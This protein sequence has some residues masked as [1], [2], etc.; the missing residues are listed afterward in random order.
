[1]TRLHYLQR[2]QQKKTGY[3]RQTKNIKHLSAFSLYFSFSGAQ[4]GL[5]LP[6]VLVCYASGFFSGLFGPVF[7]LVFLPPELQAVARGRA[8]G[9]HPMLTT[10]RSL[11]KRAAQPL[12]F[13]II[14]SALSRASLCSVVHDP[15][16][17]W[18]FFTLLQIGLSQL[19]A[20]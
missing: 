10:N 13:Q 6:A 4:L 11:H 14:P 7:V 9:K 19:P 1:M 5:T 8:V 12:L 17:S 18:S 3:I 15:A 20:P 16:E 2:Q